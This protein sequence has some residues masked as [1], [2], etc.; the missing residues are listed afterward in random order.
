MV[1]GSTLL[2]L[3]WIAVFAVVAPARRSIPGRIVRWCRGEPV[4]TQDVNDA[5]ADILSAGWERDLIELSDSLIRKFGMTHS[6]D[7]PES[8]MGGHLIPVGELPARYRQLGGIYS[9][10]GMEPEF[11]LR[12]RDAE[13]PDRIVIDWAHMRHA[14]IIYSE[15]PMASPTGFHVRKVSDRIDVVADE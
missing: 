2:L 10:M 14:V 12:P 11:A 5:A 7:L 13:G 3:V 15:R 9:R 8:F 1:V 4:A 6:N